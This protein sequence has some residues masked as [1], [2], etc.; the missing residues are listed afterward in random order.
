MEIELY[1][2]KKIQKISAGVALIQSLAMMYNIF[3]LLRGIV[4]FGINT[5]NN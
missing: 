3:Y 2:N 1:N 5:C 4:L